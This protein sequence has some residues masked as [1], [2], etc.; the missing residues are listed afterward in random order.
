MSSYEPWVRLLA[1][2][3]V[4]VLMAAWEIFAPRRPQHIGRGRRWPSNI[5]V[6]ALDTLLVRLLFPITAVGV[7]LLAEARGWG[8]FAALGLPKGLAIVLG[9]ILLDLAIYLQHVLFHAVPALWRLHRM[10]HSDLEFDVTTGSRFH[11]IEILLSM[12]IKLGVVAALGVPAVGVLIFEVLLN[13][14]SMFNHANVRIRAGIDRILRWF[15]VTPD[16]H[17][18]HHSIYPNETNSNFG[19]N[20][21]WW[22]RLFGTYR[23][24]PKDGHDA[25]VIGINQFRTERD[26]RLDQMLIQPLRGTADT[27]PINERGSE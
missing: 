11:P 2:A 17:R 4:F 22:D 10:H 9:V 6:V 23:A 20:L 3:S 5:G 26:L 27:Y 12:G 24:Q 19:F 18:V 25:M 14:T 21:P 8:L 16:M 7:A 1:F 13:A 15:V